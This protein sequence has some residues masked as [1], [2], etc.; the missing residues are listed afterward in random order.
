VLYCEREYNTIS[1]KNSILRGK[2]DGGLEIPRTFQNLHDSG[3]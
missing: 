1:F 3:A 2:G